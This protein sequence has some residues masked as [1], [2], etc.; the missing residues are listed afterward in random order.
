[1]DIGAF[2]SVAVT[3]N[4]GG[5]SAQAAG[6][7]AAKASDIKVLRRTLELLLIIFLRAH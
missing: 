6:I 4:F 3:L 2:E 1:V 7:A 5:S